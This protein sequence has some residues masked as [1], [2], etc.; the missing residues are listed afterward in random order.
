MTDTPQVTWSAVHEADYQKQLLAA[1]RLLYRATDVIG[2]A[3]HGARIPLAEAYE[4]MDVPTR[5]K[6]LTWARAYQRRQRKGK[7]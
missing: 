4:A 3:I 5:G 1:Y 6:A 2:V 7:P